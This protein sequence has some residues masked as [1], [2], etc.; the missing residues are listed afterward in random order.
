MP[1]VQVLDSKGVLGL[2]TYPLVGLNFYD[3]LLLLAIA[4]A[5]APGSKYMQHL[6]WALAKYIGVWDPAY[7]RTT[8]P[9]QTLRVNSGLADLDP[10]QKTV[11][12]DDLGVGLSLALLDVQFGVVGIMDCYRAHRL[13]LLTL[14]AAGKHRKMPDFIVLLAAPLNGSHIIL[15]E[16]KGS[17]SS[18]AYKAQLATACGSQLGN[19]ST[20]GGAAATTFPRVAVAAELRHGKDA[21]LH[22]DD[23]VEW[24]ETPDDLGELLRAN[25][26]AQELSMLGAYDSAAEIW[27]ALGLPSWPIQVAQ[28]AEV[29][30]QLLTE[31]VVFTV[32][33]AE[34]RPLR[35][36]IE[37]DATVSQSARNLLA[38]RRW[39]TA[40]RAFPQIARTGRRAIVEDDV[41]PFAAPGRTEI[42]GSGRISTG[43]ALNLRI[44]FE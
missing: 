24:V 13:G 40:R 16:C 8:P 7:R 29:G 32:V 25:L 6:S 37:W 21:R 5:P 22:V 27:T 39:R 33:P 31:G 30:T 34:G 2:G 42:S 26:C 3:A 20:L 36:R 17:Q 41:G 9:P 4:C 10:H 18:G 15:L 19:V 12:S 11:L 38:S 28:T 1:N 23:P 35:A 43:S 14:S 44:L